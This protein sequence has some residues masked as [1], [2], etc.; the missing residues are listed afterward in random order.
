M[1]LPSIETFY[2]KKDFTYLNNFYRTEV[3]WNVATALVQ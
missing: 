1:Y 2:P 3:A